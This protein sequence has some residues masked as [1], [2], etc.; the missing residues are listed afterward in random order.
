MTPNP[1]C[2]YYRFLNRS[3]Q[4][5]SLVNLSDKYLVDMATQLGKGSTGSVY[6]GK[7]LRSG[8]KVAVKI[9]ELSTIDNEVTQYLLEMEKKALLA[10]N[11]PYVLKGHKIWQDHKFCFMVTE[12]CNGGTLKNYIQKKGKLDEEKSLALVRNILEG[13]QHLVKKGMVHRDLKPANIMIHEDSPKII[14]FGY[15]EI[16]GYSKPSLEYNVGSPSYMA[17][18]SFDLNIYNEKT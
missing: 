12:Y 9:I 1:K 18:E 10:I 6:S 17:P 4:K 14:D 15:C 3:M 13:Y 7:D 2:F 8:E 11:S 5:I 16:E